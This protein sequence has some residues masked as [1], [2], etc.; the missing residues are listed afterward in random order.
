MY[1]AKVH[2]KLSCSNGFIDVPL[3]ADPG[4]NPKQ[5]V[6]FEDGKSSLTQFSVIDR[7]HEKY[8]LFSS[9]FPFK[10]ED[11]DDYSLVEL[12]PHTGRLVSFF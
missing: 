10:N 4:N 8:D 6:N 1:V 3:S 7:N 12:I 5:K 11:E 2:G 9:L